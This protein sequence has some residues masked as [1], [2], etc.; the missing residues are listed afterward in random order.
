MLE[1]FCIR[2]HNGKDIRS[3]TVDNEEF[4][5]SR[6]EDELTGFFK[7]DLSLANFLR[8]IEDYGTCLGLKIDHEKSE[9][10]LLGNDAYIFQEDNATLANIKIKKNL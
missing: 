8:L 5:L 6:Y 4:E 2:V 3:I 10:M 1:I 9:I 7:N